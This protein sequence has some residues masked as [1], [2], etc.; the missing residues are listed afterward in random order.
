MADLQI[1][2]PYD[3]EWAALY[4]D[5]KLDTIGDSYVAEGKALRLAGVTL[6]HSDAPGGDGDDCLRGGE[7]R[8]GAAQT[9]DE[10]E[11]Y[12]AD[13]IARETRA[14]ELERQAAE[15]EGQAQALRSD[16]AREVAPHG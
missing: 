10:L 12:R 7:Y 16:A 2:Y 11:V 9:L 5:G 6:V 1:H 15:L 13:R 14:A 8:D 3:S 4:V